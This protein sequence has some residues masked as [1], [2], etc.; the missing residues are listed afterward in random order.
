MKLFDPVHVDKHR[1]ISTNIDKYRH[2]LEDFVENR[3]YVRN[4][5]LFIDESECA[6]FLFVASKG[7]DVF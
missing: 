3:S 2:G 6:E 1:Q 5:V 7:N 4:E